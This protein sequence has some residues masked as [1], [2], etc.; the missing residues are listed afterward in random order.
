MPSLASL[1]Q[2]E[3]TELAIAVDDG[4]A[5]GD[6]F[7]LPSL[8]RAPL[9]ATLAELKGLN[10][11]ALQAEGSRSLAS[12]NLRTALDQLKN[13]LRDGFNFVQ[14]L[15]G[16]QIT[17]G[18]RLAV[19]TSY[20]WESGLIGTFTDGRIESLANE[21]IN[22]TPTIANPAHR[23]PAALVTLIQT[24]LDLVN[25]NQPTATGGAAQASTT[26]T[27]VAV[28]LLT[29]LNSRVRFFYCGAS[30]NLDQTDELRKIG[31]Q[32]RRD[33]GDAAGQPLPG[34]TGTATFD[35]PALTL[36]LPVLP[37]SATSLRAFRQPAGGTAEP[38]G[39]STTTTVSVVGIG[40]LTP[41]VTYQFWTVGHNSRGDGPESNRI[42]HVAS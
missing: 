37:D 41:G 19:L 11:A 1:E 8:L 16:Y 20:G 39:T 31:R 3:L 29:I 14:G 26:A 32:P 17:E 23:Y 25:L 18:Q 12:F 30:N 7:K 2:I 4:R 6:S 13:L 42:T 21:A 40:P 5:V 38:C 28:D 9:V 22:A 15:G 36:A 24:Q 35:A 10:S 27:N 34:P 33:A